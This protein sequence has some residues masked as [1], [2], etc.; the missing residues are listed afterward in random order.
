MLEHI[1][2][3][4]PE[5]VI[6]YS[7]FLVKAIGIHQDFAEICIWKIIGN[8]FPANPSIWTLI[9]EKFIKALSSNSISEFSIACDCAEKIVLAYPDCAEIVFENL[10]SVINRTFLLAG[11][12]SKACQNIAVEKATQTLNN[13]MSQ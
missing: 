13:L 3:K 10:K 11:K 2:E 5:R 12:Q 6:I 7:D 9:K 1:S 4:Y 8:I